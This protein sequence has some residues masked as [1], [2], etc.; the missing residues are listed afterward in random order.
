M[1]YTYSFGDFI[2]SQWAKAPQYGLEFSPAVQDKIIVITGGNTGLGLSAACQI[3]KYKPKVL[4]ITSRDEKKGQVAVE[5]ITAAGGLTRNIVQAWSLDLQDFSSV[6]AFAEK[7]KKTFDHLDILVNNAGVMLLDTK[8]TVDGNVAML[9]TNHLAPTMLTL[10]LLPSLIAATKKATFDDPPRIINVASGVHYWF[11][12]Q[13]PAMPKG[14]V[15]DALKSDQLHLLGPLNDE[16]F[17]TT[18][19]SPQEQ[20]NTTKLFNVYMTERIAYELGKRNIP[21]AVSSLDPGLTKTEFARDMDGIR[22]VLFQ[23]FRNILGRNAEVGASC[24]VHNIVHPDAGDLVRNGGFFMDW[25]RR[26][27]NSSRPE[28]EREL[29]WY[30]TLKVIKMDVDT[31]IGGK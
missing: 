25:E 24:L 15:K 30:E 28:G 21:I 6:K 11:K 22:S 23:T 2:S 26:I 29:V 13:I 10:L 9:Q 8:K 31:A 16:K 18:D 12:N 1:P 14:D 7:F 19:K 17:L 4:I 27:R 3:A 20:Y 5:K